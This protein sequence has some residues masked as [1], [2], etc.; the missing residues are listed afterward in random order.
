MPENR[1]A[2][3]PPRWRQIYDGIERQLSP[4]TEALIGSQVFGTVLGF[5]TR[6]K[7]TVRDRITR[8]TASTWH[9]LNLPAGSDVSRI[10]REIGAVNRQL[11]ILQVQIEASKDEG[12]GNGN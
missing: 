4:R 7:R 8:A 1:S 11:R 3:Q 12:S 6:S 5:A 9:L 2:P 10:L